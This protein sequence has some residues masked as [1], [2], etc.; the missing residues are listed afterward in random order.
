MLTLITFITGIQSKE[1]TSCKIFAALIHFFVL[2]SF[3]WMGVEGAVLYIFL[4]KVV[5][6]KISKLMLKS[7]MFAWGKLFPSLFAFFF[8]RVNI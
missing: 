7:N 2:A 4:A 8:N 6:S 1:R 3:G 5:K